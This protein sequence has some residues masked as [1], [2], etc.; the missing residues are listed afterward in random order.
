[1]SCPCNFTYNFSTTKYFEFIGI[2]I[3]E[4]TDPPTIISEREVLLQLACSLFRQ[5]MKFAKEKHDT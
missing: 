4:G 1:M 3:L 5:F 2:D